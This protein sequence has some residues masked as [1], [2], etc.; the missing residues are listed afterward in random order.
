MSASAL[1]LLAPT[2]FAVAALGFAPLAKKAA[3]VAG[4]GPLPVAIASAWFSALIVLGWMTLRGRAARLFRLTDR[5]RLAVLTVG[6]LGSGIVPLLAVLAMTET[7]AS[8][9]ALFQSA[10]PAATAI[11]AGWLLG[12][13]LP[14]SGYALIAVVCAGLALVNVDFEAAGI[15]LGWPFWALLATLPLIG[16][17]DVIAKRSLSALSPEVVAAG[18]AFGGAAVLLLAVP[19]TGAATWSA[20]APAAGWIL[21]AGACMAGFAIGLYHVF[22]MTRASIAAALIALAPLVTLTAETAL[23]NV[24]LRPLQGVG[25][26]VVLAAVI[27]LARQ[28]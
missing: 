16:L 13:R 6:A 17:A 7:S 28:A 11:A 24:A 22:G 14:A 21:L 19:L 3:L 9:R 25:F 4:A 23:L 5:Q 10:Y 12:E 15:G 2:A 1:R 18:R 26:A 27:A 8:N 20:A